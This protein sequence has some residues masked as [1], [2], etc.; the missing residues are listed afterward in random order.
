[1]RRHPDLGILTAWIQAIP[2]VALVMRSWGLREEGAYYGPRFT[3][4]EYRRTRNWFTAVAWIVLIHSVSV[5][6]LIP[7]L[8]CVSPFSYYPG[9]KADMLDRWLARKIVTQPG[10][11]PVLEY[12]RPPPLFGFRVLTLPQPARKV[13]C[14]VARRRAR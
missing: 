14:R 13:P 12:G 11:G 7:P 5:L 3:F 9:Y 10:D 8:R 6:P 2:D 1:M 4:R